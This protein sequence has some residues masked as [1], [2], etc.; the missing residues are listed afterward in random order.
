MVEHFGRNLWLFDI[1]VLAFA[2]RTSVSEY[3]TSR[4]SIT[5]L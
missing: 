2:G 4:L 3:S 1:Q 5:E